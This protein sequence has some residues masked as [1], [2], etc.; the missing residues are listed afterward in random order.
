MPLKTSEVRHYHQKAKQFFFVLSGQATIEVNGEVILLNEHEG[1]EI[2]PEV[3]HQMI[4][5]SDW[6]IEFIV[7]FTPTSKGDRILVE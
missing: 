5:N 6:D 2:S 3:P 1:M 7:V 4:N